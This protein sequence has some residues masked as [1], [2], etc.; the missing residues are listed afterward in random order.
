MKIDNKV[1]ACVDHSPFADHVADYA[2]WA[3]RR[4]DAP[5]ELLHVID[6]HPEIGNSTDHS[7]ALTPN[8]QESLLDELSSAGRVAH[9]GC[10]RTGPDLPEPPA[11]AGAC[12]RRRDGRHAPA[13]RPSGRDPARAA[14]AVCACSC[15][16]GA[17][18]RR[19]RHRRDLGRNVERVVRALERPVLVATADFKAPQ[20]VLIRLRRQRGDAPRRRDGGRQSV[21]AGFAAG[22]ADVGKSRQEGPRQMALAAGTLARPDFRCRRRSPG[23]CREVIL[24]TIASQAHRP[25]GH[26]RLQPFAT[27]QP[28][29]RQQDRRAFAP[30]ADTGLVVA[31]R[32]R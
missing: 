12:G 4:M 21:A 11:R 10:A 6:R 24:Q 18:N 23:G 7:G 26:G 5:L 31:L 17:A 19:R 30:R 9:Q 25:A 15:S 3:A 14:G 13:P 16:A 22:A 32:R 29:V 1:L 8:A 2:A 20:R 28:A 27:A